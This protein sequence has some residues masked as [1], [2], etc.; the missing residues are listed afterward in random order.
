MT[1]GVSSSGRSSCA[2]KVDAHS[3]R[4][5]G[6]IEALAAW[7]FANEACKRVAGVGCLLTSAA[8]HRMHITSTCACAPVRTVHP[9]TSGCVAGV[10]CPASCARGVGAGR[11]GSGS[12]DDEKRRASPPLLLLLLVQLVLLVLTLPQLVVL[13]RAA[14]SAPLRGLPAIAAAA[15]SCRSSAPP[16][17]APASGS[18]APVGAAKGA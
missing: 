11:S 17:P 12:A 6:A 10:G 8:W 16:A 5:I 15:A 13:A 18:M 9:L 2:W 3:G 7:H 4:F 1:P 14:A